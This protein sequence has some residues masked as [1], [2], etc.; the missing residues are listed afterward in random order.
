[1]CNN[2]LNGKFGNESLANNKCLSSGISIDS[3]QNDKPNFNG[4][5]PSSNSDI[6]NTV[7]LMQFEGVHFE[8]LD[9]VGM[10]L[11]KQSFISSYYKTY[12]IQLSK[13]L[14]S[15]QF[16]DNPIIQAQVKGLSCCSHLSKIVVSDYNSDGTGEPNAYIERT[17]DKCRKGLCPRCN[18]IKASKNKKRFINAYNSDDCKELF[19]GKYFYFITLTLKHNTTG[20]RSDVYLNQLKKY[21]TKL[22]RSELWQQYFPYSKANPLSGYAQSYELTITKNGFHIHSHILMCCPRI[23]HKIKKV[24]DDFRLKWFQLTG[25]STGFN[26]DLVRTEKNKQDKGLKLE[27]VL[28]EI[29]K[30]TVKS[31]TDKALT[32]NKEYSFESGKLIGLELSKIDL[33]AQWIICTK[34]QKMLTSN[35]FFKGLELFKTGKSKWDFLDDSGDGIEIGNSKN[36]RYF[37]GRTAELKYNYSLTKGYLRGTRQ[38]VLNSVYIKELTSKFIEITDC[39]DEFDS[40][41]NM[42]VSENDTKKFIND[43]VKACIEEKRNSTADI[44][45]I[46]R[47]TPNILNKD[48]VNVADFIQL[49]LFTDY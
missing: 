15:C 3:S 32:D 34:G 12:N 23:Q 37:V 44:N 22:R 17:S 27:R 1:M 14:E 19:D 38:T 28:G 29:L 43:W 5:N 6:Y 46:D 2:H 45:W 13:K 33:L 30:Y 9:Y 26:I 11:Q 41:F 36:D 21:V 48:F 20:T 4:T 8:N 40:Y 39:V 18:S 16:A 35:G 25:D 42:Q 24:Q 47:V 10:P 31:G 49:D 7:P